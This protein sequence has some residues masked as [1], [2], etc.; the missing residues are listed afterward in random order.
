MKSKCD[1]YCEKDGSKDFYE[2][3]TYNGITYLPLT[4]RMRK[5]DV[6]KCGDDICQYTET[7]GTDDTPDN[8]G[9]DCGPCP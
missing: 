5:H 2:Q 6:F 3:C 1:K 9:K 8:C 4:T 7:C